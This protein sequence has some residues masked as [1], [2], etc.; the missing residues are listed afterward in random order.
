MTR[1]ARATDPFASALVLGALLLSTAATGCGSGAGAAARPDRAV[2]VRTVVVE[3]RDLE[4]VVELTGTLRPRAQVPVVAEVGARLLRVLRD[5]GSRVA[6]G[7]TLALLDD[8]DYRLASQRAQAALAMAEA[9]RAHA[10]AERERAENLL[11]TGGITDKDRLAA[12]V[13]LQVADA[14]LAQAR[15]E[16]AIA[17]QQLSR[18]SV[19]A[20]F[21]GRVANRLVD[22][23]AMLPAGT[24]LL[25]LVDDSVLEFRASVPSKH[26]GQVKVD[27]PVQV[28]VEAGQAA[29]AGRVTRLSPLVDERTRAFEAVV[30]VPPGSGLVGGLF[31]RAEVRRGERR[32][33]LV[34]PA[35]ALQRNGGGPDEARVFVVAGGKA[36][37]R[38][39]RVGVERPDVV[40]VVEGLKAGEV[41]VLDP[42]TAL[43]PGSVVEAVRPAE[44]A[45]SA[46]APASR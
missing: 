23:G 9:N 29:V 22:P 26:W 21:A 25:T 44:T 32:G 5:E 7:E 34:V 1:N 30:E 41:V 16:A 12:E 18:T 33:A 8:T 2:P 37:T 20:P 13:G 31:A 28:R 14:A 24:P 42:P 39:V 10:R 6:A 11:R 36:E 38:A 19:K 45:G 40:E 3:A 35:A 27:A 4:E 46:A 43:S 15:A 17:D